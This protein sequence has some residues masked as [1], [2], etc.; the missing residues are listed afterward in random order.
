MPLLV[1]AVLWAGLREDGGSLRLSIP[2][3]VVSGLYFVWRVPWYLS[4][5]RESSYGFAWGANILKNLSFMVTSMFFRLDYA[6]ILATWNAHGK[7]IGSA[8]SIPAAHPLASLLVLVSFAGIAVMVLRGSRLAKSGA[9]VMLLATLPTVFLVGTGERLTYLPSSGFAILA[10]LSIFRLRRP[11]PIVVG[12]LACIYML[13]VALT[14]SQRWVI[15]SRISE[16]VT[17]Q[18]AGMVVENTQVETV[19]IRGLPD[20]YRGA[21]LFRGGIGSAARL[22][23]GRSVTVLKTEGLVHEVHPADR[24]FLDYKEG[25]LIAPGP[26]Q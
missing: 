22:L 24:L 4:V 13:T 12:G 14:D 7:G 2:Y 10:G 19:Y 26:H 1:L 6:R 20:N 9:L 5:G 21:Y 25:R 11:Y 3:F 8:L 15:A 17:L 16:R 18:L 23:S